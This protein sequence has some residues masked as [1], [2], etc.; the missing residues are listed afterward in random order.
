M[1][2]PL[3]TVL[4]PVYNAGN[5]VA[6]AVESILRQT[7]QSF[8]LLVID[9][10]STD[11][12]LAIVRQ[13]DDARIRIVAGGRNVGVATRLNEGLALARAPLVARMD[14]DDITTPE[15]LQ[16]QLAYMRAHPTVAISGGAYVAFDANGDGWKSRLPE[17]Q[18]GIGAK[19][20]FGS[21][22]G[23]PTA[24]INRQLLE[25][26]RLRYDPTQIHVEDYDLWE[27]A[28][29]LVRMSNLPDVLLKYRIHPH[30]VSSAHAALQLSLANRIRERALRRAGIPFTQHE[31]ATHCQVANIWLDHDF[32]VEQA[33][34]WLRKLVRHHGVWTRR[35]RALRREC[36][37]WS[38]G[39]RDLERRRARARQQILPPPA[40]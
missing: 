19:L 17:T 23:H 35:G 34:L 40:P 12:S 39:I 26:A 10:G 4:M 37:Y 20:L 9:D 6:V 22:L 18:D 38:K 28:H 3:I 13:F 24:I 21:P 32:N 25:N 31:L 11:D 14:A 1:P 2:D 8:E 33:R 29:S 7:M 16:R 30:Q 15:R 27:R 5:F 36:A